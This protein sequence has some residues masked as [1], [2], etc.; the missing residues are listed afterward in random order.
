[1][2]MRIFCIDMYQDSIMVSI[3]AAEDNWQTAYQIQECWHHSQSLID[4]N[5][6][7]G[8]YNIHEGDLYWWKPSTLF[9]RDSKDKIFYRAWPSL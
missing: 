2:V 3:W 5:Y 6:S 7:L 4:D 8:R 9:F 1:M